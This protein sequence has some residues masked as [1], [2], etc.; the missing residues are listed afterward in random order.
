MNVNIPFESNSSL[1]LSD[2]E[3]VDF[4]RRRRRLLFIVLGLSAL[5]WLVIGALIASFA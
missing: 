4:A 1:H 2:A 3:C 5:S